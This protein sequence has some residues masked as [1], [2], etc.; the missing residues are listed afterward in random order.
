MAFARRASASWLL[1]PRALRLEEPH[2]TS[3]PLTSSVAQVVLAREFHLSRSPPRAP[4]LRQDAKLDHPRQTFV[5]RRRVR[6][7]GNP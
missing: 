4:D 3:R 1:T 5:R 6:S 7:D 2:R